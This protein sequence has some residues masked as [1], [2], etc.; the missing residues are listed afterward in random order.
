MQN[1]LRNMQ[2]L[3]SKQLHTCSRNNPKI[4]PVGL[5]E[6]EKRLY[7]KGN[8]QHIEKTLQNLSD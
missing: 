5:H 8:N 3:F 7:R 1:T 2:G 6:I 4:C